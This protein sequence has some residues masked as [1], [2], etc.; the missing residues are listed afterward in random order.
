MLGEFSLKLHIVLNARNPLNSL[1]PI[2]MRISKSPKE[3]KQKNVKTEK[4]CISN[5]VTFEV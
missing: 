1:L 5:G 3:N 2:S 4:K